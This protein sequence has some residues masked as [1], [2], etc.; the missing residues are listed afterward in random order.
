[1]I[2]RDL[3]EVWRDKLKRLWRCVLVN[4]P[5]RVVIL[6]TVD[7]QGEFIRPGVQQTVTFAKLYDGFTYVGRYRKEANGEAVEEV[8][9]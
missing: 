6:A 5:D 9:R 3:Y 1:M 8:K 2:E 7:D 4:H